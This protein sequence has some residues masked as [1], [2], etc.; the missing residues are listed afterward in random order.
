M[1]K[2]ISVS[3]FFII[4]LSLCFTNVN[5]EATGITEEEATTLAE[6]ALKNFEVI[7]YS[8]DDFRERSITIKSLV[9]FEY[10]DYEHHSSYIDFGTTNNEQAFSEEDPYLKWAEIDPNKDDNYFGRKI[11]SIDDVHSF[12]KE[13]VTDELIPIYMT[14]YKDGYETF[15]IGET[16]NVYMMLPSRY[17]PITFLLSCDILLN[18]SPSKAT[19][20]VILGRDTLRADEN[21]DG[22]DVLIPYFET[23]EFTKT[24][25]GWRVSGGTAFKVLLGGKANR[26]PSTGDTS[27]YTAPTLTVAAIISVALPV[28]LLRK[29]R[30]VV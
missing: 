21:G 5:A 25:D 17:L 15:K 4:L 2:I 26:N 1:K 22:V 12:L 18:N 9:P 6:K 14:H 19:M 28:T 29:R 11:T 13:T 23:V 24:A 8:T 20:Q 3:M 30:R 27:S 7:Q 10:E 16:G